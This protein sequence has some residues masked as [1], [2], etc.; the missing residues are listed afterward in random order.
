MK[1]FKSIKELKKK[2]K[3]KIKEDLFID[4]NHLP[5]CPENYCRIGAMRVVEHQ[6]RGKIKFS[7]SKFK[8]YITDEQKGLQEKGT[9]IRRALKNKRVLNA[10]ILDQLIICPNLIPKE[11]KKERTEDGYVRV[12]SFFGTIYADRDGTL[13]VRVLC[14]DGQKWYD[15]FR[16]LDDYWGKDDPIVIL[17]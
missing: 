4:C 8:L 15:D 9:I 16:L 12:I 6:K 13:C 5:C 7:P 14:W 11:W 17:P 2:A 10:N 3:E 1:T